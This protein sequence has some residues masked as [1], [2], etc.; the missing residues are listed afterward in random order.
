MANTDLSG[1]FEPS[2]S[3][4]YEARSGPSLS[5]RPEHS[6]PA[7]SYSTTSNLFFRSQEASLSEKYL[8]GILVHDRRE[9]RAVP[10][11]RKL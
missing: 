10:M 7:A 1:E 2:D 11:R 8:Q 6:H 5:E 9:S 3:Y 4:V